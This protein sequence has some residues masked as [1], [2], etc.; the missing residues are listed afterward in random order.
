ML[1]YKLNS[2][3]VGRS[4]VGRHVHHERYGSTVIEEVDRDTDWT[5]IVRGEQSTR[6][7]WEEVDSRV[8]V[9]AGCENTWDGDA[10]IW[11]G[12]WS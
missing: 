10:N 8:V 2:L 6:E 4:A 3:L 7:V 12:V 9:H 1:I 5:T 11:L